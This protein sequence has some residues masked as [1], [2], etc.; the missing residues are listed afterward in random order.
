MCFH[1]HQT[2][3]TVGVGVGGGDG[4]ER[5]SCSELKHQT[6]TPHTS[7]VHKIYFLSLARFNNKHMRSILSSPSKNTAVYQND[8]VSLSYLVGKDGTLSQIRQWI[9]RASI[10]AYMRIIIIC[11]EYMYARILTGK[12]HHILKKIHHDK[13]IPHLSSVQLP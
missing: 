2:A 5:S 3:W 9:N 12:L 1:A 6:W 4:E 10:E 7:C 11:Q 8:Y 13:S